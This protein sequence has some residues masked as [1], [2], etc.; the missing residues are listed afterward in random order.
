LDEAGDIC[1]TA[2]TLEALQFVFYGL[3]AVTF[4]VG[5]WLVIREMGRDDAEA[6]R[7]D[8]APIALRDGGAVSA[9]LR[10]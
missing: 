8:I 7:F 10:F 2:E 9:S 1:S 6:R 4:G 5:L 3:S